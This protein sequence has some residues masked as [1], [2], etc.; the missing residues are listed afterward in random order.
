M[1]G[2]PF[3]K[4]EIKKMEEYLTRLGYARET[5][6]GYIINL[7]YFFKWLSSQNR[8]EITQEKINQYNEYLHKKAIKRGT[9][10]SRLNTIKLYDKY[11]QKVENRKILTKELEIKETELERKPEILTQQE[12][13]KLYQATEN[14]IKGYLERAILAL[15][16]GCGLRSKEGLK[17]ELKDINYENNLIH[18][19]PGKNHRN[20]YIPMSKKVKTDLLNYVKYSR[21]YLINII[22][23]KLLINLR[24]RKIRSDNI[25][26]IIKKLSEQANIEKKITLHK[27]RHSIATHLL[28]EG[29]QLEQIAQFLGHKSIETTQIYTHVHSKNEI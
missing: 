4:K 23:N 28:E 1:Q 2:T 22:T 26:R 3:F 9:I 6:K 10:Q 29:M 20:R 25:R 19:K 15:Y 13:Q 16:Y 27:L 11:L 8:K 24:G 5:I 12:I 14:T 21:P 7:N 17:I 18:I